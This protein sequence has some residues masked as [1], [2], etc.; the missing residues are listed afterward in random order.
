MLVCLCVC[1]R[2][3]IRGAQHSSAEIKFPEL[4]LAISITSGYTHTLT[5][6]L[7]NTYINT[8]THTQK[9]SRVEGKKAAITTFSFTE[10]INI[11]SMSTGD[12]TTAINPQQSIYLSVRVSIIFSFFYSL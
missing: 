5:H 12:I 2:L 7:T 11:D 4:T 3:V 1:V 9:E 10:N 8:H 6:T